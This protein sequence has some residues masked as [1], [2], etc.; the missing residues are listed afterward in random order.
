M[1]E[2]WLRCR[3]LTLMLCSQLQS[4]LRTEEEKLGTLLNALIQTSTDLFDDK[5]SRLS[6]ELRSLLDVS[7]IRQRAAT[8]ADKCG[9]TSLQALMNRAWDV[10]ADPY[11]LSD[12]YSK[13]LVSFLIRAHVA[14]EHPRDS[15]RVRLLPFQKGVR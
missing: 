1:H 4:K 3:V 11:I 7:Q 2:D 15:R 12:H 5:N 14:Q 9:C 8:L 13:S 6:G 10:P